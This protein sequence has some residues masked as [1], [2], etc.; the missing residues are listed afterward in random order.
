MAEENNNT[1]ATKE[2]SSKAPKKRGV[3]S[4]F[5]LL[6]CLIPVFLVLKTTVL[7]LSMAMIPTLI[8]LVF[9]NQGKNSYKFKWL[10]V[11]GMNFAG[12]LPFLFELW[13]SANT[14]ESVVEIF[15]SPV[16]I[17]VIF[18]AA[19]VGFMFSRFIPPIV[20]SILSTKDQRYVAHLKEKQRQLFELW[21][22]E[23]SQLANQQKTS[24]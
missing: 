24:G 11:G 17:F 22:E 4:N 14:L 6:L 23:V 16:A 15:F 8:S 2:V 13:F 7:F 18:G 3:F 12:S 5:A 1:Q 9:E 21:G 20:L 10:S 19:G